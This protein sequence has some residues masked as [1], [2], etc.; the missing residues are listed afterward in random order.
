MLGQQKTRLSAGF[1]YVRMTRRSPARRRALHVVP[2][3]APNIVRPAFRQA[4]GLLKCSQVNTERG[5]CTA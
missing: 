3:F 5:Q 2:F 4:L 1:A